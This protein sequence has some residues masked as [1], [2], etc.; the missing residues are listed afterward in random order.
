MPGAKILYAR[1]DADWHPEAAK[2]IPAGNVV[3][4]V[5]DAHR[6]TF[7]DRLL[8]AVRDL[9]GKR[10]IK[11]VLGTRP[12]GTRSDRCSTGCTAG[13]EPCATLSPTRAC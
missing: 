11:L 13:S 1:E 8:T 2:E 10:S 4:V 9:Q 5:D 6:L 12:S 3:I 7:L